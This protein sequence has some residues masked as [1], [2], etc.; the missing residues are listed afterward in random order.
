M[1]KGR[2]F[3]RAHCGVTAMGVV[4]IMLGLAC[5]EDVPETP[6]DAGAGGADATVADGAGGQGGDGTG[7]N[8]GSGGIVEPQ[9]DRY[10]PDYDAGRACEALVVGPP[11]RMPPAGI[12]SVDGG[13]HFTTY[14]CLP[15]P[16]DGK[17]CEEAYDEPCVLH[18]YNCG[19]SKRADSI[20]CGPVSD[21]SG[22]CCYLT[23]GNCLID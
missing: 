3:E 17:T 14:A 13:P 4:A 11:Q 9:P 16:S 7:G 2:I 22:D 5:S 19:L 10:A 1:G 15:R 23:G 8:G 6:M 21:A 12:C 20:L 18:T